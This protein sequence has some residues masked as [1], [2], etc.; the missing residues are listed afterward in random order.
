MTSLLDP[1]GASSRPL[2]LQK[3]VKKSPR[4]D[5]KDSKENVLPR[6]QPAETQNSQPDLPQPQLKILGSSSSW[7]CL[8]HPAKLL[9]Q[10]SVAHSCTFSTPKPLRQGFKNETQKDTFNMFL[11][12][13]LLDGC[14]W[15]RIRGTLE[16]SFWPTI[17]CIVLSFRL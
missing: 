2:V 14:K 7:M 13:Y 17:L 9:W 15:A 1:H 4:N 12:K 3:S 11:S 6:P 5:T 10:A 16:T 8:W